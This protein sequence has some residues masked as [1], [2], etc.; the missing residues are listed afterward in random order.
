V[1]RN[2]DPLEAAV[3][4]IC[5]FQAGHTDNVIPQHA[6]LRGTARALKTDV[7]ELLR[8]RIGE[9]IEG[10]ARLYG[11]TAKI[12]YTNG[13]PVV[14]N[15]ERETEFASAVAR[16]IAGTNKVNTDM[17]PVMG[18]EDF[19]FMLQERPGAFIFVGNGDSAGLH[20][21]AYDFNDEVIPVGT[22]YWVRLAETALAG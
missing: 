13:Y 12:T 21:P 20:H 10:T 5:M 18:A 22:S 3:V 19:A 11:A 4:S 8:Q 7:R 1:A 9:V 16:E 15:R 17:P 2:V 6:L 14:V